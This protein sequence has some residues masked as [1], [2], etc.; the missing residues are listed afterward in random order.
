MTNALIKQDI[1]LRKEADNIL[2]KCGHLSL[3][4][5]YGKCHIAGI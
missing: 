5:R 3:L 2:N 4:N 1:K